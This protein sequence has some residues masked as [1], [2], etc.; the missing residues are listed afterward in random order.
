[1]SFDLTRK[2]FCFEDVLPP[3]NAAA[4][5][6]W[7]KGGKGY[8]ESSESIVAVS[9]DLLVL[10][11]TTTTL[12]DDKRLPIGKETN[13]ATLNRL[14]GVYTSDWIS[15]GGGYGPRNSWIHTEGTCQRIPYFPVPDRKF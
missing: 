10:R 6:A 15:D 3:L 9:T 8:C 13:H 4:L 14:S 5:K 2:L 1:M 7:G 12:I 11:D